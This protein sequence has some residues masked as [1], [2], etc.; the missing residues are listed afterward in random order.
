M[1]WALAAFH[2]GLDAS[3]L[4]PTVEDGKL[5]RLQVGRRHAL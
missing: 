3:D 4:V 5:G 2:F 1:A